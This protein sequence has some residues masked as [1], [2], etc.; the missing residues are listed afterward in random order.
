MSLNKSIESKK[1]K[2]KLRNKLSV[3]NKDSKNS[4]KQSGGLLKPPRK[5]PSG[6]KNITVGNVDTSNC[7]IEGSFKFG[8][9]RLSS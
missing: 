4:E 3:V 1:S 7:P 6:L 5:P 2:K 9:G 8:K